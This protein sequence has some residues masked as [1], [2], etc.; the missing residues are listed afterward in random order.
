MK[1]YR[2]EIFDHTLRQDMSFFDDPDHGTG[3]LVARLSTEPTSIQELLSMNVALI[4]INV[5]TVLSSSILAIAVGWKLGLVLVF[6]ALPVLVIGGYI[7]I[8]LEFK[9]DDDTAARFAQSSNFA[10]EAVL[11][12]RTVSALALEGAI[13][14]RYSAALEGLARDAMGSLGWKMACYA[15]SQSASFLA[16]ALGFW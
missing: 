3:S 6:G 5:V 13:I 8:R 11:G 2:A 15:L 10:S 9:L 14:E 12:I 16:M 1:V 4:L 7:R